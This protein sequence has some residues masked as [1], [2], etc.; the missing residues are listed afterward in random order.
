MGKGNK[1]GVRRAFGVDEYGQPLLPAKVSNV[2]L[3]RIEHFR[4][5]GGCA[6]CYPHG[7]ETTNATSKK[8]RRSWKKHRR[9]QYK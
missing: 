6:R 4:E 3:S 8:N 5:R 1:S 9:R 7:F 2:K